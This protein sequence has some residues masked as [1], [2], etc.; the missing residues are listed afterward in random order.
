MPRPER[1]ESEPWDTLLMARERLPLPSPA[2]PGPPRR[3]VD[4]EPYEALEGSRDMAVE[5]RPP[6]ML[7]K[8]SGDVERVSVEGRWRAMFSS[9]R[10]EKMVFKVSYRGRM[11]VSRYAIRTMR[12]T[13][14]TWE[15][16][17]LDE[18]PAPLNEGKPPQNSLA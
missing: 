3:V 5:G 2:E 16:G 12:R 18:L 4:C 17:T 15:A 10:R 8:E 11:T 14:R 9:E 1:M 6:E 7:E 13:S